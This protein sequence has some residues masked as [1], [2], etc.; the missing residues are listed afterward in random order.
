MVSLFLKDNVKLQLNLGGLPPDLAAV[1]KRLWEDASVQECFARSRE[2]QLN[3]SAS[4][5]LNSLD[6]IA[7][8][9]YLPT[10]DLLE[11]YKKLSQPT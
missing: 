2:Y 5:Y 3:D 8:H 10:Q 11:C 7:A 9:G 4:Y 6:R 1:M